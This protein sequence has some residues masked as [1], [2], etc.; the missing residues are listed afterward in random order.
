MNYWMIVYV[1]FTW[2]AIPAGMVIVV[3]C[4]QNVM[5]GRLILQMEADFVSYAAD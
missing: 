1:C 2:D 5:K 4:N 3:N